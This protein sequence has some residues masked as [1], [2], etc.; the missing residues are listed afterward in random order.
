MG[1]FLGKNLNWIYEYIYIRQTLSGDEPISLAKDKGVGWPEKL[2]TR[3]AYYVVVVVVGGGGGGGEEESNIVSR[4]Q[5][6]DLTGSYW[7]VQL[8]HSTTWML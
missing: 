3:Y 7:P 4:V 5:F 8:V 1:I 2:Y 6:H